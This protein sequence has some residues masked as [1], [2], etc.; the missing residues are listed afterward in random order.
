MNIPNTPL[1]IFFHLLCRPHCR[2]AL[3][4][5]Q[6]ESVKN[7]H[8][9]IR[10]LQQSNDA[11]K[12]KK[13]LVDTHLC[14]IILPSTNTHVIVLLHWLLRQVAVQN[15]AEERDGNPVVVRWRAVSKRELFAV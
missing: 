3:K 11:T 5:L 10:A 7:T 6:Q 15:G 2:T 8:P 14:K 13:L 1:L 9:T 4:S 12:K